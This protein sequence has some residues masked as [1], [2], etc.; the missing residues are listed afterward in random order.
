VKSLVALAMLAFVA[1]LAGCSGATTTPGPTGTPG[2]TGAAAVACLPDAVDGDATVA[3]VDFA[4]QPL[5]ITITAGQIVTWTNTGQAPHLIAL[6]GGPAC[7][8][9]RIGP[10]GR[11]SIQFNEAREYTYHCGIHATMTGKVTVTP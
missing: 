6:D 10:G 9:A 3:V 1:F 7:D 2:A 5:D 11:T 4:F 8:D